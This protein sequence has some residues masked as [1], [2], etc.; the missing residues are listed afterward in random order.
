MQRLRLNLNEAKTV[1]RNA[2]RECFDF[3]GYTF[4]TC[5]FDKRAR[6][7]WEH[8]PSQRSIGR[9]KEKV[10]E[11]SEPSEKGTWPE[12]CERLNALLRGWSTYFSHGTTQI[13]YRAVE[14][15]VYERVRLVSG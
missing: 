10:F 8:Q 5:G 15:N 13:A 9:L 3:L 11:I 6:G 2:R 12:V 1:I 14:R 4:G 7:I